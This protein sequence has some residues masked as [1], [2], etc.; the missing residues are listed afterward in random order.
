[1]ALLP[2]GQVCRI[3]CPLDK[4][5]GYAMGYAFVEFKEEATAKKV[6]KGCKRKL[7]KILDT[8]VKSDFAFCS[9]PVMVGQARVRGS[10]Q[11]RNYERFYRE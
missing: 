9:D 4:K 8:A 1:M 2:V 6:I 10:K 11:Y 3:N 7:L 5:T